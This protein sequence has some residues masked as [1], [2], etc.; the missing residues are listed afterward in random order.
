MR[1]LLLLLLIALPTAAHGQSDDFNPYQAVIDQ[2]PRAEAEAAITDAYG[3]M[4]THEGDG[5]SAMVTVGSEERGLSVFLFCDDRLAAASAPVTP[6][7]AMTI[8]APLTVA[9][10][11]A[12]SVYPFEEGL[13]FL[14]LGNQLNVTYRNV[15]TPTSGILVTYPTDVF[16]RY[17][18]CNRSG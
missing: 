4:E 1:A 5:N 14:L 3:A 8:L 11:E 2:M 13:T 7:I 16:N 10:L 15:G 12:G 17:E 18:F 9:G 6:K